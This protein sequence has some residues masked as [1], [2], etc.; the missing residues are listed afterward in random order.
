MNPPSE[1]LKPTVDSSKPRRVPWIA[2][3][4]CTVDS[5]KKPRR[6]PWIPIG[7]V[8]LGLAGLFAFWFLIERDPIQLALEGNYKRIVAIV[9]DDPDIVNRPI[10]GGW[11]LL[12]AAVY[13]DQPEIVEFLIQSGGDP[14]LP[15]GGLHGDDTTPAFQGA[16]DHG[17]ER[18]GLSPGPQPGPMRP[19]HIAAEE[20]SARAMKALAEGGADLN[21]P[22]SLFS[23]P[24]IMIAAKSGDVEVVRVL[25][26]AGVD[27]NTRVSRENRHDPD[28]QF[29]DTTLEKATTRGHAEVV[30]LL[31]ERGAAVAYMNGDDLETE[32]HTFC[33]HVPKVSD[34][35]Y[36]DW[37][38]SMPRIV[39][40][41]V[42][43]LGDV[44]F[45]DCGVF[46]TALHMTMQYDNDNPG[47]LAIARHLVEHYPELNVNAGDILRE[48][49]LHKAVSACNIAGV[50]YLL[51]N[52]PRLNVN[53]TEKM[54][55]YTPLKSAERSL[56]FAKSHNEE[57]PYVKT[58]REGLPQII[59]L[60]KAHGGR[61][62]REAEKRVQNRRPK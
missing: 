49:P 10:N 3:G 61:V 12:H 15:I 27:P 43:K 29:V 54:S 28:S 11:T 42:E 40:L 37:L 34:E 62:D 33:L 13:G 25:L 8:S 55:G 26:D 4:E 22:G 9:Q 44:N 35:Q 46:Q 57:S 51:E 24:P 18:L 32:L 36:N 1:G 7:L 56:E 31:L 50:K 45:R 60:L 38:R 48:T 16:T 58:R 17:L 19:V 59:E 41:L 30:K 20:G 5:S 23:E 14:N 6:V 52:C 53:A 39:D 47:K 21:V 2:I